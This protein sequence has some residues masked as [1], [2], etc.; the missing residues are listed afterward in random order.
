MLDYNTTFFV[1]CQD[2]NVFLFHFVNFVQ[3]QVIFYSRL[4]SKNLPFLT[5]YI[6]DTSVLFVM[7]YG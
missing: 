5:V 1:E 3:I 2:R 4:T 7:K 6:L